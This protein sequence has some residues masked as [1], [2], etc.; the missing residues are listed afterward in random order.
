VRDKIEQLL[1]DDGDMVEMYLTKKKRRM[2]LNLYGDQPLI[3]YNSADGAR[4]VL[5]SISLVPSPPSLRKLKKHVSAR[6]R[7]ESVRSSE[8]NTGSLGELEML[9]EAYFVVINSTL[10]NL[11]SVMVNP[12]WASSS[13]LRGWRFGSYISCVVSLEGVY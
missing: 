8:S 10:N 7:L 3:E 12:L 13:I 5:A 9:L 6:R 11:T 4:S 2:E 1:D